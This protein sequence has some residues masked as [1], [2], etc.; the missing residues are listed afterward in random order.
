M[1]SRLIMGLLSLNP[2]P[3]RGQSQ[4]MDHAHIDRAM[5]DMAVAGEGNRW[6]Q[7]ERR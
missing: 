7:K 4:E 5:P 3:T 2:A 6:R 1:R